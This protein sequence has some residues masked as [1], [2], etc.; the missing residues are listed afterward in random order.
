MTGSWRLW[1]ASRAP[2]IGRRADRRGQSLV[3]F[4]LILPVFLMMT[5]AI[6]DGA[7]IFNA[8]VSL[9]NGV[10]EAALFAADG[11]GYLSFCTTVAGKAASPAVSVP[12][13]AGTAAVNKV[14]DPDN[15]A[16][17]IDAESSGMDASLVVLSKPSC[18]GTPCDSV[19]GV[20][21][22][23]TVSASYPVGLFVTSLPVIGSVWG[24]PV[25]LSATTTAR[26][27]P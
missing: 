27:L 7:R 20:V 16:Y 11:K 25:M 1:G 17:R 18:D 9:T 19:S 21:T 15:I 23:V 5:L 24:N 12:C 2:R 26:V 14:N 6:V 22:N 8:Y 13:P 4:A 10:R 3:E